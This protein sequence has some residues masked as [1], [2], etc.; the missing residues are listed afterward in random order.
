VSAAPRACSAAS[1]ATPPGGWQPVLRSSPRRKTPAKPGSPLHLA[2]SLCLL[3]PAERH[4][5]HPIRAWVYAFDVGLPVVQAYSNDARSDYH[6]LLV[7]YVRRR[8]RGRFPPFGYQ[9]R[10]KRIREDRASCGRP[11]RC[12]TDAGDIGR[13][14]LVPKTSRPA[15][16]FASLMDEAAPIRRPVH[17]RAAGPMRFLILWQP[18]RLAGPPAGACTTSHNAANV[19]GTNAAPDPPVPLA[20]PASLDGTSSSVNN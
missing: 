2:W 16:I 4:L 20:P 15:Q 5:H 13:T 3:P 6:A 14:C 9:N 10:R 8:S 11:G 19:D 17:C 18:Y 12:I 7:E 1:F